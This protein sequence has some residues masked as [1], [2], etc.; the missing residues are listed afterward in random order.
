M[1]PPGPPEVGLGLFRHWWAIAS[2]K[3]RV[4]SK[5]GLE[6]N[7]RQTGSSLVR[8]WATSAGMWGFHFELKDE[9]DMG[10]GWAKQGASRHR[11]SLK[12]QLQSWTLTLPI[13]GKLQWKEAVVPW[14][15]QQKLVNLK[16]R[17]GW[18]FS[19]RLVQILIHSFSLLCLTH[20]C[21]E[22]EFC[23]LLRILKF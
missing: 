22:A 18:R 15:L 12:A 21:K 16:S 17:M 2:V 10:M 13:W 20:V 3:V 7:E 9:W 5:P 1:G 4:F 11:D 14:V 8:L 19:H 23:V 6:E